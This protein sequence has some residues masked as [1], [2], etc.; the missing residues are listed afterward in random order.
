M[1]APVPS[2][3]PGSTAEL[4]CILLE[5][6]AAELLSVYTMNQK[7]HP[8]DVFCKHGWKKCSQTTRI[9]GWRGGGRG[10]SALGSLVQ[11]EIV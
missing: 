2:Y 7:H 4:S 1:L 9:W 10:Q 6:L 5:F 8:H 11:K 3:A